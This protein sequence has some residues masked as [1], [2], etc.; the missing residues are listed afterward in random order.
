MGPDASTM[1]QPRHFLTIADTPAP[2]IRR[3]LERAISLRRSPEKTLLAGRTLLCVFEKSSLRT[4]VSFEQAMRKLG[5]DAM[6]MSGSEVGIGGRESPRDI[7]RVVSSMVDGVMARV[8]MHQTLEAFA[9]VSTVPIINGLSDLAHPAQALADALTII[10][11]FSP[12]NAAGVKGR[13]VA[14]VGDG[15]N[16]ARSL[17]E[18]CAALGMNFNICSPA[19]YELEPQW[20]ERVQP[21]ASGG[22]GRISLMEDPV[23]AVLRADVV[24]CDTFVSMGQENERTERLGAFKRYQVNTELLE[25]APRHAIVLHCLP[26]SR[27]VEITDEVMDGPRSRVFPQAR[28]RLDAQM[29]L[30]AELLG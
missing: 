28:N 29:G 12:G 2:A 26:A 30:L 24:Y 11:E 13:T 20:A 9:E 15:N 25:Q 22:G 21:L 3:M 16:V 19:R 5:G 10:D 14:F 8:M 17:G 7:S 6:S 4:R 23:E 27:G 18:I 1:A